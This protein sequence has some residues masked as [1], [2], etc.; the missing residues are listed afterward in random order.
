[1]EAPNSSRT[2]LRASYVTAKLT[3]EE[4]RENDS[5][6][7]GA[8]RKIALLRSLG[9]TSDLL[10]KLA[11]ESGQESPG[12]DRKVLDTVQKVV[13][14]R[15]ASLIDIG[16]QIA[17]VPWSTI[18][19]IV[20]R[21]SYNDGSSRNVAAA[22]EEQVGISPVGRLHL[23]KV[24]MY[25]AGIERGELVFTVPMAPGESIAIS[26]KEWTTSNR[27]YEDI[28][29]DYFE[30]YSE[31]GVTEKTD[32]S[33]STESQSLHTS[34][35]NFGASVSGTYAGVTVTTNLGLASMST[36]TTSAKRSQQASREVT[37]KASARARQEHKVSVKIETSSGTEDST[38]KNIVNNSQ[39][40]VRIDYYRMMR[41]WK[42]KLFRYGLRQTYDITIPLPGVRIWAHHRRMHEL[43]D[44]LQRPFKFVLR[45]GDIDSLKV[46]EYE[47]KYGILLEK[48]PVETRISTASWVTPE[49]YAS[50]NTAARVAQLSFEVPDGYFID[51]RHN[52]SRVAAFIF[53]GWQAQNP[54]FILFN[55][56]LT[57]HTNKVPT[58]GPFEGFSD[59]GALRG[60]VGVHTLTFMY[61]GIS[62]GA[63]TVSVPCR[64]S[65]RSRSDWQRRVWEQI[66][67]AAEA[68]YHTQIAAMQ[69]ERDRL[70]R[71]LNDKDT[72][73][74]RRLER[75]ELI[76][77][78]LA[79]LLGPDLRVDSSPEVTDLFKKLEES[80]SFAAGYRPDDKQPE[81]ISAEEWYLGLEQ[82]NLTK[83]LHQAVEW[84]NLIYFLYPYFWGTADADSDRML[85][86]HPDPEHE[87][88]LRAGYARVVLP[89]RPGFETDFTSLMEL[90][91]IPEHPQ[92]PYM[93]IATEIQNFAQTNY[94]GVP[95]A[96]PE[97]SARP[98]LFPEQRQTWETIQ[99]AAAAVQA[100]RD[101]H[102]SYPNKLSDLPG[103]E[104]VD[105]WNYP[106]QYQCPGLGADFDITSYGRDNQKDT[107][108]GVED[109][110]A[111]IGTNAAASLIATWFDYTPSSGIDIEVDTKVE[112]LA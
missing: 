46:A 95:P 72:L 4:R 81:P 6:P 21:A 26:H 16:P 82:G 32:V 104:P 74:L 42:S 62:T 54:L 12:H 91:G 102:G 3:P 94:G 111:D 57:E 11:T 7:S 110:T 85:F 25:P 33:L 84:E 53:A 80:E 27:Q 60:G 59:L 51:T 22:I 37:E 73:R 83:F 105:A 8:V 40:A 88:F 43:D 45:P 78:I 35:M 77:I 5:R 103:G 31:R 86:E 17:K 89:I 70:Y 63:F 99:K 39:E 49:F 13:G 1:M 64:I 30:S 67:T 14:A 9:L 44:Q 76:R 101:Q 106:L 93:T 52:K 48:A 71:L 100:Y 41:K 65:D 15:S 56:G 24:E 68:E 55:L 19:S 109:L 96:N 90:G 58:G 20:R 66:R 69:A 29:Q 36:E 10:K 2:I 87:R 112:E 23:E 34:T 97:R 75:E 47:K 92:H 61:G 98:L 50:N 28:V 18:H 38:F 79:W 108:L 107:T